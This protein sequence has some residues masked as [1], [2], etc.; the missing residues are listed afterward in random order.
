MDHNDQSPSLMHFMIRPLFLLL[1]ILGILILVFHAVFL[2]HPWDSAILVLGSSFLTI[3]ITLP[4]AIYFQAAQNKR[5]FAIIRACEDIGIRRIFRSRYDDVAA[6]RAALDEAAGNMASGEI[7]LLGIAFPSLFD[8]SN[9]H[10][11]DLIC[12]LRD[13]RTPLRVALLNPDSP[14]AKRRYQVEIQSNTITDIK[15]TLRRGLPA[16]A[17]WRLQ[18]L[19]HQSQTKRNWL[20]L[21]SSQFPNRL[22]EASKQLSEDIGLYVRL[23]DLDPILFLMGFKT[24]MFVEQ[25][26]LG[27]AEQYVEPM[28]CIGKHVPVIQYEWYSKAYSFF[29]AHYDYIWNNAQPDRACDIIRSI[30]A[31]QKLCGR[32]LGLQ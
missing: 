24:C 7:F 17:Y 28:G 11:G 26:H 5:H 3:G 23:Y 25:Y 1:N 13:P 30:L 6:L 15:S 9:V 2:Q 20:S 29:A 8:T 16:I 19:L 32:L 12:R 14:A 27:R 10:T 21:I 18:T 22:T 4:V 31:D